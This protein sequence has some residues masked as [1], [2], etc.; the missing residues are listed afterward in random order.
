MKK[1]IY[2]LI[3]S[4]MIIT[5]C[6]RAQNLDVIDAWAR[7]ASAGDNSAVYFIVI[8]D[9]VSDE[10]VIGAESDA[11]EHV[12][13]HLSA[14]KEDG[15]MMMQPQESVPIPGQSRIEF[16]PG[17]YHIMLIDLK[18]DLE[19][20]DELEVTL[21]FEKSKDITLNVPVKEQ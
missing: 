16:K 8:N 20:G 5:G 10:A 17:G 13:V 14:M 2:F 9:R 12:E 1:V 11:A 6:Q 3:I 15:T 19:V 18:Q 21:K 4:T 7:S